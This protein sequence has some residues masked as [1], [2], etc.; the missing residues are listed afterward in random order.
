MKITFRSVLHSKN[1]GNSK[2]KIK[3]EKEECELHSGKRKLRKC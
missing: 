3:K 2:V 1:N